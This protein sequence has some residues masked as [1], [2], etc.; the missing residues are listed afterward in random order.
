[1][2]NITFDSIQIQIMYM[3]EHVFRYET[4]LVNVLD[5]INDFVR[6][7]VDETLRTET[8]RQLVDATV[9]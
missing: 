9:H 1:M 5:E 7:D 6:T 8:P 3:V 2:A 4:F